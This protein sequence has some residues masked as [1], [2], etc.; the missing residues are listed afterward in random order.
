MLRLVTPTSAACRPVSQ[1]RGRHLEFGSAWPIFR[2]VSLRFS[3][4]FRPSGVNTTVDWNRE[5]LNGRLSAAVSH[6]SV[7]PVSVEMGR[8]CSVHVRS[9]VIDVPVAPV[10]PQCHPSAAPVP[11]QCRPG[12]ALIDPMLRTPALTS[13]TRRQ[14]NMNFIGKYGRNWELSNRNFVENMTWNYICVF[15]DG[16]LPPFSSKRLQTASNC[17]QLGFHNCQNC[18]NVALR[19]CTSGNNGNTGNW[20][21]SQLYWTP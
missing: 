7:F 11:P 13:H 10:P 14:I 21:Q 20:I 15:S 8:H 6:V 4:A 18:D 16:F 1:C 3:I 2:F 19:R 17:F 12:A 5:R 9:S